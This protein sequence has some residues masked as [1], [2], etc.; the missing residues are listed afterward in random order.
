MRIEV[1]KLFWFIVSNVVV[2]KYIYFRFVD[3]IT[4]L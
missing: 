3:I 2:R 4:V 1:V